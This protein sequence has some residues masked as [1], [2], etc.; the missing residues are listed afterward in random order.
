MHAKQ[1]LMPTHEGV[2]LNNMKGLFPEFRKVGM[3]N[4]MNAVL[5][6]NSVLANS[7]NTI[8]IS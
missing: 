6:A 8:S 3:K 5:F 7:T 1:I 2:R 4:E